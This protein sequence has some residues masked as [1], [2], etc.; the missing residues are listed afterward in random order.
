MY[1]ISDLY[2]IFLKKYSV[3]SHTYAY[4]GFKSINSKQK[5]LVQ[6]VENVIYINGYDDAYR[7][8]VN[9]KNKFEK[10]AIIIE[11]YIGLL[12]YQYNVNEYDL[13]MKNYMEKKNDLNENIADD[14]KAGIKKGVDKV[15]NVAKKAKKFC[16]KPSIF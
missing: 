14:V 8:L 6:Y 5:N 16:A 13:H 9:I 10:Y 1:K 11:L 12:K 7:E 15:Q 4:R 2:K 3:I